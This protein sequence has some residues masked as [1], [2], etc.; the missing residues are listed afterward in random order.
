MNNEILVALL[1]LVGT[2]FG[3]LMGS[4]SMS[5]LMSYRVNILEEKVDKLNGMFERMT[6]AE[7]KI[8]D[9]DDYEVGYEALKQKL[10][11]MRK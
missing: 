3:S 9:I 6:V 10:Q 7:L 11:E 1:A 5:K 8:K 4:I 2:I